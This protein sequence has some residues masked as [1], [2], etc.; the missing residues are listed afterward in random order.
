MVRGKRE[1]LEENGSCSSS[2]REL[3]PRGPVSLEQGFSALAPL[4]LWME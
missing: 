4:T 2:T 1:I 3:K